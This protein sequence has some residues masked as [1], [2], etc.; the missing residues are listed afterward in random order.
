MLC[1]AILGLFLATT[2]AHANDSVA[3]LGAGGLVLIRAN[4][5][6]GDDGV[7]VGADKMKLIEVTP[8]KKVVWTYTDERP[9]GIHH[10]QILTTNGKRLEGKPQR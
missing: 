3:Q 10:F 1:R 8:G 2:V 7:P 9:H 4:A 6:T 5:V